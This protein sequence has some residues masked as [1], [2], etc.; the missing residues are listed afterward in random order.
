MDLRSV[1]VEHSRCYTREYSLSLMNP[2]RPKRFKIIYVELTNICNFTCDYCPIDQ[3]T[4]KKTHMTTG[5][6][7]THRR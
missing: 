2:R 1:L 5:L 4:C 7:E 6:R 3:Q